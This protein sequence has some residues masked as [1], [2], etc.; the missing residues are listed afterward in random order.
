MAFPIPFP[1]EIGGEYLQLRCLTEEDWQLE[2]DLS[3]VA[4]VPQ[5]TFYP[6][7]LEELGARSRIVRTQE[8]HRSRL[9]ARYAIVIDGSAMGT[10]GMG[11][12]DG[13]E[14]EI[15]YVLKPDARGRGM[16]TQS[17][18]L[19]ATWLFDNGFPAV[20]LETVAG[21]T[22]SEKVAERAGFLQVDSYWGS[23]GGTSVQ[24]NR[25]LLYQGAM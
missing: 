1:E 21:N 23:Q 14:P 16:A 5:W 10:V 11:W 20:A 15:F 24:V 17:V 22:A 12:R 13:G 4:D 8:R 25:W 7:N 2:F 6:P 18:R 3:R 9:A 19:L